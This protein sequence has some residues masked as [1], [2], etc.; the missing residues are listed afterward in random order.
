MELVHNEI[1]K[2]FLDVLPEGIKYIARQ[3][4]T[5]LVVEDV[6]CPKG[7]SLMVDTVR[8]HGEPA[9]KIH[10]KIGK[11]EGSF[12][13]DAFW[14]SHKKLFDFLPDVQGAVVVEASCPEC[15]TSLM[16]DDRCDASGCGEAKHI[17]LILPRSSWTEDQGGEK[18]KV[19]V[20][21]RLGC[22][23]HRLDIQKVPDGVIQK[24]SDINFFGSQIDDYFGGI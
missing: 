17:Q 15:G 12:F 18:N 3:G 19:L 24:I 8:I 21:G 23:G 2:E 6:R 9:I 5:F 1:P 14:G 16:T 11:Q 22:P 13:I 10:V 7:H 4:K 20:C